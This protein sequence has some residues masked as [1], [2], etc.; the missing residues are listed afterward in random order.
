MKKKHEIMAHSQSKHHANTV[1]Q[2]TKLENVKHVL[3]PQVP[4]VKINPAC[5][6]MQDRH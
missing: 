2:K 6:S 5:L 4:N 3:Q 1:C